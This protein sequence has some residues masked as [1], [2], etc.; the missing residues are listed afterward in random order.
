VPDLR[1]T[2]TVPEA[3]KHYVV[4]VTGSRDIEPKQAWVIWQALAD[5]EENIGAWLPIELL[6]GECPYGGA[7]LIAASWAA[8]AGWMVT[9]FPAEANA[10]WAYAKR[11]KAMVDRKP[12]VFLCF[13]KK[14]AE[15]RGTKMTRDMAKAAGIPVKEFEV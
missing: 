13:F 2:D 11:N 8:G 7:D 6:Q 14:G 15:N 9:D 12:D 5:I 1:R 3:L 4:G 10:G